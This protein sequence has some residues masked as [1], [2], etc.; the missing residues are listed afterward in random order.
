MKWI[1]CEL[2]DDGRIIYIQV[3]NVISMAIYAEYIRIVSKSTEIY[4]VYKDYEIM[5]E[6]AVLK[7]VQNASV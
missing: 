6:L 4:D 7:E 1:K 2:F 3:S 5:S